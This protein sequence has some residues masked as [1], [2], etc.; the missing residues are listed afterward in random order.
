MSIQRPNHEQLATIIKNL[1]MSM[2]ENEVNFF[3]ENLQGVFDRYDL[4]DSMPDNI[5]PVLYPRTSGYRPTKEENPHNAWY[6]KSEITGASEGKLSNK[7][8]AIKDN[9]MVAGVPMMNGA[10][11]LEGFVPDVDATIVTR[12]LDAGG[13]IL[14]KA[15]C[16]YF[17][18][19]GGS[20]TS[21]P[22][23]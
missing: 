20:H 14:G 17:C 12:I 13:K 11:T 15:T 23:P 9:V 3:L 19:S 4:I 8:I 10:S 22:A 6:W 16:E 2:D 5:T 18:L 1:G 21:S 7:T